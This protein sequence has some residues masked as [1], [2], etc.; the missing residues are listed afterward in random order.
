M[1][2]LQC[3]LLGLCAIVL[4]YGLI[5][6]IYLE[7]RKEVNKKDRYIEEFNEFIE[8]MR[9]LDVEESDIYA[10]LGSYSSRKQLIKK[11]RQL[12]KAV[13]KYKL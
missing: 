10:M 8:N 12:R 9:K 2:P 7:L 1:Y 3:I 11:N 6:N 4:G 5:F 13:E